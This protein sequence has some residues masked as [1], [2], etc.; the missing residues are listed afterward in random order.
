[1][2]PDSIT[3]EDRVAALRGEHMLADI[4]RDNHRGNHIKNNFPNDKQIRGLTKTMERKGIVDKFKWSKTYL[5]YSSL[6]DEKQP[7][8]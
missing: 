6:S 8:K 3:Y 5:Y 1:M 7:R 4:Q 2:M